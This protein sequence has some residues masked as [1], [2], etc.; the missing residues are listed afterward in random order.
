MLQVGVASAMC[1]SGLAFVYKTQAYSLIKSII[2]KITMRSF[3]VGYKELDPT[4]ASQRR[5]DLLRSYQGQEFV[6]KNDE[7]TQIDA[8]YLTAKNSTKNVLVLCLNTTYQDHHPSHWEPFYENGADILLW[9]P[10]K[11]GAV[12]YSKELSCLLKCLR[13]KN[14]HQEIA[15]KTYCASTDP[16]I[17]AVADQKDPKIHLIVDRGHGDIYKLARSFT[18]F[19]QISIVRAVLKESF[20]CEGI[21]KIE[22]VSGRILFITSEIDQIMDCRKKG[23]LTR[24]LHVIKPDQ[25]LLALEEHDHWSDWTFTTYNT[26]LG[27]LKES[28]I[29]CSDFNQ[30]Q[31]VLFPRS[32]PPSRFKKECVPVLTKTYF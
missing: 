25:T 13:E 5:M 19:A 7:E 18:I 22:N 23:N 11:L 9:N 4:I 17:S 1:A 30:V 29:V 3:Y 32:L 8:I 27:F 24:D 15:V 6:C 10:T 21:R 14:P 31:E 12:S 2:E 28:G 20:D 16:G 26:V